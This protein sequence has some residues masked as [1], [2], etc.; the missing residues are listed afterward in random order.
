MLSEHIFRCRVWSIILY[1]TLARI[2]IYCTKALKIRAGR[3]NGGMV[4]V[5][6]TKDEDG[7]VVDGP[8]CSW[9]RH[10]QGW[11]KVGSAVATLVKVQADA[12]HGEGGASRCVVHC[13]QQRVYLFSSMAFM[14]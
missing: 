14:K 4:Y 13:V 10:I 5:I 1:R 12:I 11:V 3:R 9:K 2:F 6:L 8:V 7:H